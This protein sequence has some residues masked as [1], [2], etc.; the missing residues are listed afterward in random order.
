MAIELLTPHTESEYA[1]YVEH[2][3]RGTIEFLVGWRDLLQTNF[4]FKPVYLIRKNSKEVIDGVL[5]LSLA[6][7]IF[8]TR[9][10][11]LP[12]AVSAG[13]LAD[14]EEALKELVSFAEE[15]ARTEK[16][17]FIEIRESEK[18]TLYPASFRCSQ[19]VFS[20]SL[21][22]SPDVDAVW[23]K[24]PKGSV[25]WGIKKAEKS[26]LTQRHGNS[27]EYLDDFYQL[28][29]Q[30]RK[31]RG[32]PAYPYSYLKG[33]M[34]L[35]SDKARIYIAD[36]N[37]KPVAGILLLYYKQE[38]RYAFAGAI[39]HPKILQLQ[40][41]HLLLW[42]AVKDA[43]ER[44]YT[45]FNFGGAALTTNDGGLYEFKKKWADKIT[46]IESY[47]YT[48]KKKYVPPSESPLFKMAGKLWQHLP[49]PIVKA[50]SPYVIRQF[51]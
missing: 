3:P 31:Y 46:P 26:G 27:K 51:V 18:A 43:C 34:D 9:L 35:F 21:A 29:L 15:L 10:V 30:T 37:Q 5:P 12:Y 50:V 6:K 47:V 36:Y 17:D 42:P 32:V 2:H 41:Y 11:S 22:L 23:K 8:G 19:S 39:P 48:P 49:I 7:S 14:S 13:V 20:F 1:R 28:F 40:P 24:L 16:V 4:K 25:R 45:V 44:G 38:V 33:I